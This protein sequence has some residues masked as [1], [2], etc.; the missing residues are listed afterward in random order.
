MKKSAWVALS[1]ILLFQS[2]VFAEGT[3][4]QCE[5]TKGSQGKWDRSNIEIEKLEW[6][7]FAGGPG[8]VTIAQDPVEPKKFLF[9]SSFGNLDLQAS[10]T[11]F[12]LTFTSKQMGYPMFISVFDT[13]I[14]GTD[15]PKYYAVLSRHTMNIRS[16]IASQ[17]HGTCSTNHWK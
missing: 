3:N 8:P 12:G 16:P 15:S 6:A 10:S 7:D 11:G 2:A 9:I 17:F 5:F 14:I 1:L 4:F 13:P